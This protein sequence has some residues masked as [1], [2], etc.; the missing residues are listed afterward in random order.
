MSQARSSGANTNTVFR[1]KFIDTES[2][3]NWY[4]GPYTK[5]RTVRAVRTRKV[6]QANKEREAEGRPLVQGRIQKA[7]II[8]WEDDVETNTSPAKDSD[9]Q[10]DRQ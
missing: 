8:R 1:I 6:N 3:H 10:P 9:G 4:V 2:G 7:R 5:P